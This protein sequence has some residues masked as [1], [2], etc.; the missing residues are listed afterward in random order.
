VFRGNH[1]AAVKVSCPPTA[2]GVSSGI[3]GSG[4]VVVQ[5]APG[6]AARIAA[7]TPP[8]GTDPGTQTEIRRRRPVHVYCQTT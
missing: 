4:P 1:S 7:S 3:G 2:I 6:Q 5:A 8:R